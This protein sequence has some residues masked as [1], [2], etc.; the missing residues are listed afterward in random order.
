LT[1]FVFRFWSTLSLNLFLDWKW[2]GKGFIRDKET[3]NTS[4]GKCWK[5]KKLFW[6][7]SLSMEKFVFIVC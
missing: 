6:R 3:H 1:R 4:P 2:E 7:L 5:K